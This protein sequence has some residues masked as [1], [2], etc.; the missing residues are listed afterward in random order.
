MHRDFAAPCV[1]PIVGRA[2]LVLAGSLL[3]LPVAAVH[4]QGNEYRVVVRPLAKEAPTAPIGAAATLD[5]KRTAMIV[6]GGVGPEI[7]GAAP[8]LARLDLRTGKWW[9]MKV[10]GPSPQ[11][12]GWPSLA[13]DAKRDA[14][15]L[16]GGW[17][18]GA[19]QPSDELWTLPLGREPPA[20]KRLAPIGDAPRARNGAVMVLDAQRDRLL[21]HGG[22]GGPH[23]TYGYTPLDDLWA[24]ELT[25]ERWRRLKPTGEIPQPCWNHAATITPESD[26]MFIIGGGGYNADGALVTNRSGHVLD[27]E[28]LVWTRLPARG[29]VPAPVQGT[30]LTYDPSARA[31][32]VVGGLS[33][34]E[35]GD[36]G[37]T[38]VWVYDLK[39]GVWAEHERVLPTTRREHTAVYDPA[40]KRHMIFGGQTARQRANFYAKG[41]P[42][43]DAVAISLASKE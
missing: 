15:F 13:Y 1:P 11:A 18:P 33:L 34:A 37:P 24:Y 43:R 38:S 40:A 41:T 31:L 26:R 8:T 2:V 9:P 35:E 7:G 39:S 22:D 32:V 6:F 3:L 23:P 27:L 14:L 10:S 42:L 12:V 25:A 29:D 36:A 16:F 30:T 28:T 19:D 5:S 4:A 17:T 21:L 20:W